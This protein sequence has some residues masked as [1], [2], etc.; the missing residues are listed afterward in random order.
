MVKVFNT[1]L[2]SA[3]IVLFVFSVYELIDGRVFVSFC[4]RGMEL[5]TCFEWI[6]PDRTFVFWTQIIFHFGLSWMFY[7]AYSREE[8]KDTKTYKNSVWRTKLYGHRWKSK[9]K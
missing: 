8:L 4:H 5:S 2:I 3:S 6:G 9:R 7:R 1:I